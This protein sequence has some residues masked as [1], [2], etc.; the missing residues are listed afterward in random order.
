MQPGLAE[1][2]WIFALFTPPHLQK[3]QE[4]NDSEFTWWPVNRR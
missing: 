3:S 1:K 4:I 2:G